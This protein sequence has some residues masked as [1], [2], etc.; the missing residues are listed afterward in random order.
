MNLSKF[1]EFL[2][3]YFFSASQQRFLRRKNT[4]MCICYC[5]RDP[6]MFVIT[7]RSRICDDVSEM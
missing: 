5:W 3:N 4:S 7:S 2:L 6:S 1:D